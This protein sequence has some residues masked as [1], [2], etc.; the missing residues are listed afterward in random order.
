MPF[1]DN[2]LKRLKES[3][4]Y[5]SAL[6]SGYGQPLTCAFLNALLARLEAAENLLNFPENG[7]A[8]EGE[9]LRQAWRKA[10]GK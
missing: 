10:A 9:R 5:E 8:E 7:T 4:A 1:D 3:L 2:D 6:G